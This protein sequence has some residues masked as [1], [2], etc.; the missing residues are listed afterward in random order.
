MGHRSNRRVVVLFDLA[1]EPPDD[2]DYSQYIKDEAFESEAAVVKAIQELGHEALLVAV[3]GDL[4]RLTREL[5]RLQPD[6]VFNLTEAFANRRDLV[7]QLAGLLE[8]MGIPYTGTQSLG[9]GLSQDKYLA[10]KI[11]SHHRIR[12]PRGVVS[13][14]RRPLR[15]LKDLEFPLFIKPAK[16]EASEGISR[17]S[18]AENE[19][20]ALARIKFLH[21]KY[22]SDVV[23]EEF[24]DGRELYV[25]ALGNKR[26]NLFPVRELA[27]R[28]FPEDEPRFATYK[29]KWDQE[30]RKKYGI[31][32][33]FAKNLDESHLKQIHSLAKRAFSAL[34]LAGFA[35]FDMR[36]SSKGEVVLLEANPNPSL[37]PFDDFALSAD[38]AGLPYTQLIGKIIDLATTN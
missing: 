14:A 5:K 34:D 38:K 21:D 8:L 13:H 20:D 33:E 7:P 19:A 36:L 10:K 25:G 27:F 12:V 23:I 17:D 11:L 22:S 35:R 30:Y 24:I 6:L 3:H 16:E 15:S 31:R 32:N 1:F 4:F 26:L 2:H 29:V 28:D 37:S 18:F 9:L